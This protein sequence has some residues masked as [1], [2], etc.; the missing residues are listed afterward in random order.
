LSTVHFNSH[1]PP[2]DDEVD[3]VDASPLQEWSPDSSTQWASSP[4][5]ERGN[6]KESSSIDAKKTGDENK[7]DVK[8]DGE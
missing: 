7:V 8:T 2:S 5:S 1:L 6:N 3:G 4:S